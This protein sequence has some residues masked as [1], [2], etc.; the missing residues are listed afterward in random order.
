[1]LL[2]LGVPLTSSL[3]FNGIKLQYFC[4]KSLAVKGLN[5]ALA[6]TYPILAHAVRQGDSLSV[7]L[8]QQA[9]LLSISFSFHRTSEIRPKG[10]T[11]I[12]AT[13]LRQLFI[14]KVMNSCVAEI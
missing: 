9:D 13:I 5:F 3:D 4:I 6:G 12:D 1:M 11:T 14:V 7:C 2:L 8:F 10:E